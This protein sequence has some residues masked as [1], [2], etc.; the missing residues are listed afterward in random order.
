MGN[1]SLQIPY[2]WIDQETKTAL[3]ALWPDLAA[4]F[5]M[6]YPYGEFTDRWYAEVDEL[7]ETAMN[8]LLANDWLREQYFNYSNQ[9]GYVG[10]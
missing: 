5:D 9:P 1:V 4:L 7:D 10:G 6:T 8:F 3:E 2:Y